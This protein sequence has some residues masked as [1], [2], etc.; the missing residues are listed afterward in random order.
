MNEN[1]FPVPAIAGRPK[2]ALCKKFTGTRLECMRLKNKYNML[3][4][5]RYIEEGQAERKDQ[6]G[7]VRNSNF[8]VRRD[9][10][11]RGNYAV[12]EVRTIN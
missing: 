11:I 9:G 2:K 8:M 10:A 3:F 1:D 12:Y 4:S 5:N 7:K 6:E